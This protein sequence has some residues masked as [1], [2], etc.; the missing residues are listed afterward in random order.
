MKFQPKWLKDSALQELL[1]TIEDA[2]GE[3]RVAGGAVRDALLGI[4]NKDVDIATTFTPQQIITLFEKTYPTGIDHGTIT[5]FLKGK[6]FEVTTLRKDVETDGR[7]AIVEFTDSWEEDAR[8]RDFTINAMYCDR[9]GRIYD[10]VGGEYDIQNGLLRFVGN[11]SERIKE[12]ALRILRFF[13]FSAKY[14]E[15]VSDSASLAACTQNKD[16][17]T[18]ISAER[19][20]QEM[21]KLIV[22]PHA[23]EVLRTMA[24]DKILDVILE[25][26]LMDIEKGLIENLPLD[27]LLRLA[28]ISTTPQYLQQDW[29]L[30][31]LQGQR[32]HNMIK[33][34]LNE[35]QSVNL[36]VPPDYQKWRA[37]LYCE[38]SCGW[39]D[40]LFLLYA[41]DTTYHHYPVDNSTFIEA[42]QFSYQYIKPDLPVTGDILINRGFKQG[43]A[44]GAKLTH[45]KQI[46]IDNDF[47]LTDEEIEDLI[48]EGYD[49]TFE[50]T[51]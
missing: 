2:G 36:S 39:R 3:A 40:R 37:Q 26:N 17:L 28:G 38:G 51:E 25:Y 1:K 44:L 21:F 33:N 34:T 8:R 11:P 48:W 16:L 50:R 18:N 35:K 24:K 22:G 20:T 10:Y 49:D 46:W 23:S 31:G 12:D 9:H 15:L 6:F 47:C 42:I 32:I 43:K 14:P 30:S 27:P 29:K 4:S 13:R 19:I 45:I 5:V 7:H 41:I